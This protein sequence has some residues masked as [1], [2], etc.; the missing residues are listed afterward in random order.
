VIGALRLTRLLPGGLH[1]VLYHHVSARPSPLVDRLNVT[2]PPELFEAHVHRLARNYDVVG[3]D[4]V[5]SGKLPTRALLITFDDGFRSVLDSALPLLKR[6][7]LPSVFFL[8]ASFLTP[9]SLPLSTLLS[10]LAGSV[11]IPAVETAVTGQPPSGR[12]L[13][14]IG[15]LISGLPYA[16]MAGLAD[17]LAER[18]E[19]DCARIRAES[20]LFLD[21]ADLPELAGFGCAVGNHTRSHVFCRA[22]AD[23]DAAGIELVA[24]RSLLETWARAPVRV[25]SYPY[26]SRLDATPFVRQKLEESGHEATFLVESRPN[27]RVGMSSPLNRVSLQDRPVSRLGLELEVLPYLRAARDRAQR[28]PAL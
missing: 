3:A 18:F 15:A 23:D 19:V 4:D 27:R 2:T 20:G 9:E 8:S 24:H 13:G 21:V 6:L 11:G 1:V 22:I 28:R 17:E 26:G 7:G 25:F 5:L 14:Q 16:R 12:T 10:W